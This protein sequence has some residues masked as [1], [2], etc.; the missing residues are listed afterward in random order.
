MRIETEHTEERKRLAPSI[1]KRGLPKP[2]R[3]ALEAESRMWN[4]N[5]PTIKLKKKINVI[6]LT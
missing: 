6:I 3:H 4:D 1:T 5:L 2:R